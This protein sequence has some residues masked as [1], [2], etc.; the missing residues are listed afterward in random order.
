MEINYREIGA[1]IRLIRKA[2][3]ITQEKLAEITDYSITHISH[4]ETGSSKSSI[5]ALLKITA[6]LGCTPNDILCDSMYGAKEIFQHQISELLKDC[7]EYEVRVIN[8]IV[9]AT[10]KSIRLRASFYEKQGGMD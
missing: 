3:N 8:D 1:R 2:R 5:E 7:T 9:K 4:I 10:K 6:A